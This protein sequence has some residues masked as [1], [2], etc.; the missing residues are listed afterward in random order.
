MIGHLQIMF[1]RSLSIWRHQFTWPK[2]T[3]TGFLKLR[4]ELR[5][6]VSGSS[7]LQTL[8]SLANSW[9]TLNKSPK[10]RSIGTWP[11]IQRGIGRWKPTSRVSGHK[12]SMICL[13]LKDHQGTFLIS[14]RHHGDYSGK[15]FKVPNRMVQLNECISILFK[16][17]RNKRIQKKM[18]LRLILQFE[19]I[20][21]K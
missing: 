6:Q 7:C 1:L 11:T 16:G 5:E 3:M 4:P 19:S 9:K 15:L 14:H 21:L 8:S 2:E 18:D 20:T 13:K 10:R 17:K 12:K